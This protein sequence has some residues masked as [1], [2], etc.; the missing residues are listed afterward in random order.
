[1]P[2][3]RRPPRAG[4]KTKVKQLDLPANLAS[5][6]SK[7]VQELTVGDLNDLASQASGLSVENTSLQGLTEEDIRSLE[8]VFQGAKLAAA[9]QVAGRPGLTGGDE[10]LEGEIF[11]N[12]S[13]CC[14]TPCC[15][16]AAADIDPFAEPA[17]A[18]PAS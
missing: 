8:E 12:W 13:C 11:D 16:C 14:C 17:G 7:R 18:L 6:A 2:Q 5:K 9:G 10:G 15:C 4:V 3:P 1:M